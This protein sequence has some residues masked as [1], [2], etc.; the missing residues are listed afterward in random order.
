MGCHGGGAAAD[1]F[2]EAAT[3]DHVNRLAPAAAG[4]TTGGGAFTIAEEDDDE[5]DD[6]EDDDDEDPTTPNASDD[7]TGCASECR[8]CAFS[9]GTA[10]TSR[11][12]SLRSS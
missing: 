7:T 10:L 9:S 6:E 8:G 3:A 11:Y 4:F 5:D 12:P 2:A 1:H